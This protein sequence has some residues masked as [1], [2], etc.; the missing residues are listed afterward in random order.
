MNLDWL[1]AL[2]NSTDNDAE[3]DP[4]DCDQDKDPKYKVKHYGSNSKGKGKLQTSNLNFK[5][6][7]HYLL[8]FI[9][10]SL[11]MMLDSLGPRGSKATV[12]NM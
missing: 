3:S 9:L 11:Q 12:H 4:F 2:V 8:Y 7:D 6:F 5:Y 10:V 1:D